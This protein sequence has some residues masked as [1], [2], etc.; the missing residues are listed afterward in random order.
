[1]TKG[2]KGF[3]YSC[4]LVTLISEMLLSPFYP[5]LFSDYFQMDGVQATS[6]F[7]V[8]CRLVVIVL[9]P[10][11]AV[12]AQRWDLKKIVPSALIIMG[13][14]KA[15]LPMVDTFSQ[16]LMTSLVLLVFQ[17]SI[18]LLYPVLVATSKNEGEKVKVTT[19]Y[20][21]LFHG[22]VIISGLAGSYAIA[23]EMPLNSYYMFAGADL[24]LALL[25]FFMFSKN[26]AISRAT[27]FRKK[28]ESFKRT[29][30]SGEF[31]LYLLIVFLFF[32][33]HHAIRPYFTVFLENS[34]SIT[35]QVSSLLYVMPSMTA[36]VLQLLLPKRYFHS[37]I[38]IILL[39][40]MAVT[41]CLLFI[42]V[43]TQH[44]WLF[45]FI[46]LL[47]GACF[48][49]G[50]AAIDIFFFQTSIGKRSPLSY[51]LVSSVQNIALLFAPMTALMM[52]ERTGFQGPFLLGG[53]LLIGAAVCM[54]LY[55]ITI[56][57]PSYQ[58]KK[59]VDHHENL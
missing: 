13:I 37:H 11:W 8:C 30:M 20:L 12:L 44:I 6:L 10:V 7:I 25:S 35:T 19:F 27:E 14:C 17:S 1:M 53:L 16:F 36:V 28:G 5:Q 18:Y 21:C 34:Y 40:V 55:F 54:S 33:G 29:K 48:F 24:I 49:I 43:L 56:F 50:L 31:L 46:R 2:E 22:S 52:V 3:I 9:T 42:Q 59:E 38:K 45:S 58:L 57:K 32:I 51:S 4:L 15:V 41:G 26:N 39:G 47:Y 23:Q